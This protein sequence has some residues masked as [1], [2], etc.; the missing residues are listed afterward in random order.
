MFVSSVVGFLEFDQDN[1]SSSPSAQMES[2][3]TTPA[4]AYGIDE[5]DREDKDFS[6]STGPFR[7]GPFGNRDEF[8]SSED[9]FQ[10]G[11]PS[12]RPGTTYDELRTRNRSA[13]KNV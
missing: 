4:K 13:F 10:E 8:S 6:Q 9:A 2:D 3:W 12:A 1:L 5:F 11:Q 7:R